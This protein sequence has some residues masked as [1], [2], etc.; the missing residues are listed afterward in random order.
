[1]TTERRLRRLEIIWRRSPEPRDTGEPFDRSRLSLEQRAELDRLAAKVVEPTL[2]DRHGLN[3]LS[4]F[5]L[6]RMAWL[7]AIGRGLTMEEPR[8]EPGQMESDR[9]AVAWFHDHIRRDDGTLNRGLLSDLQ[10]QRLAFLEA[11]L[12]EAI[13]CQ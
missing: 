7:S 2:H 6:E 9:R 13:A 10:R 3:D 12:Q 1:M 5:E 8:P 11:R 4:D